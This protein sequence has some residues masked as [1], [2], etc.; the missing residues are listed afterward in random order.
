[1]FLCTL[2]HL[3]HEHARE[4]TYFADHRMRF[5]G[6]TA[7]DVLQQNG[8]SGNNHTPLLSPLS[9]ALPHAAEGTFGGLGCKLSPLVREFRFF[10][11]NYFVRKK[12]ECRTAAS[13]SRCEAEP[14]FRCTECR[15]AAKAGPA[16]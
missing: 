15:K 11:H 3:R 9:F 16:G 2:L 13:E 5:F 8:T 1:M 4:Y 6:H 14:Q 7:Y 10:R 12:A